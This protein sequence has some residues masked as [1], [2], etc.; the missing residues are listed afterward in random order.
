MSDGPEKCLGRG[1]EIK[2]R[3]GTEYGIYFCVIVPYIELG[4]LGLQA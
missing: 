3:S 1:L 2:L 4:P